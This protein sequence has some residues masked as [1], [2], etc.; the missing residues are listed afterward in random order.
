MHAELFICFIYLFVFLQIQT[1]SDQGKLPVV[2]GGTQLYIQLLLWK[3]A[4]DISVNKQNTN[5]TKEIATRE[6]RKILAETD[7]AAATAAA[8]VTAAAGTV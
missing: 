2:V 3:S 5:I 7:A 1:L 8:A 6:A 4:V